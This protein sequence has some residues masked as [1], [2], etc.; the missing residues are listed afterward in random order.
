MIRQYELLMT[1]RINN[2]R[3][4]IIICTTADIISSIVKVKGAI[5]LIVE[6]HSICIRTI[7]KGGNLLKKTLYRCYYLH[8]LKKVD[9]LIALTEG[10]AKEWRKYHPNVLV[11][12]NFVH[13]N[14]SRYSNVISQKV[15]FVGRFDYQKR[16]TEAIRIWSVIR[17]K[18]P[19]WLLEIYGEGELKKE[20]ENEATSST[21]PPSIPASR[22]KTPRQLS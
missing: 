7:N 17:Q 22:W 3:P 19:D 15:I 11:I 6:S 9:V 14:R 16:V 4:D 8:I 10:D 5:P 12:P 2:I 20:I 21:T 13:V 18:Y 1:Q